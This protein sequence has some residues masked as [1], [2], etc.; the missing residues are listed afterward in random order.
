MQ[1]QSQRAFAFEM[2]QKKEKI[3]KLFLCH[4]YSS[5]IG[6]FTYYDYVKC[7][8]DLIL[9]QNYLKE[10]HS[11]AFVCFTED[12]L[13]CTKNNT[14]F[15]GNSRQL[16]PIQDDEIIVNYKSFT[17]NIDSQYLF[18]TPAKVPLNAFYYSLAKWILSKTGGKGYPGTK[19]GYFIKRC[20][21]KIKNPIFI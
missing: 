13:K 12:A 15:L 18:T 14:F 3:L 20:L 21:Q 8:H 7:V 17:S 2:H 6:Y 19:L 1:N 10:N 11:H 4:E 5:A 9:Q 16:Y